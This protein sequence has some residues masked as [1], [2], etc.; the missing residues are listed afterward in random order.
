MQSNL[1][2]Q[3]RHKPGKKIHKT[4]QNIF[5]TT[6]SKSRMTSSFP[7]KVVIWLIF[8]RNER[9]R[10]RHRGRQYYNEDKPLFLGHLLSF[11]LGTSMMKINLGHN[12]SFFLGRTPKTIFPGDI[13]E[14]IKKENLIKTKK[15]IKKFN[16]RTHEIKTF[17]VIKSKSKP[18][19]PEIRR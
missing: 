6:H 15:K 14:F 16:W 19:T 17:C 1:K 12:L 4:Q 5:P 18:H 7:N 13:L 9:Q 11:L 3:H 8:N 10:A 2:S